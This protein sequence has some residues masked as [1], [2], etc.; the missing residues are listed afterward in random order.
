MED[1]FDALDFNTLL[2][3]QPSGTAENGYMLCS[4]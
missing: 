4:A 2:L 3:V 1:G